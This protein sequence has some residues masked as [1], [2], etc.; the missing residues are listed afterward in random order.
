VPE[1]E[2]TKEQAVEIAFGESDPALFTLEDEVMEDTSRWEIEYS[3]VFQ[4]VPT[5]KYYQ[6]YYRMGATEMQEN[7]PFECDSFP[8]RPQ[9]VRKVEKTVEV[10][11]V[12]SD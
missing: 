5:G 10:W 6:V 8:L 3:R 4:H 1:L 12:V 11:E 9:Q 2:L 7:M